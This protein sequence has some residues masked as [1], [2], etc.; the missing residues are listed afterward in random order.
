[1]TGIKLFDIRHDCRLAAGEYC[2]LVRE[3]D[4]EDPA[5]ATWAEELGG[6]TLIWVKGPNG[7][8][9]VCTNFSMYELLGLAA[10][11]AVFLVAAVSGVVT[12]YGRSQAGA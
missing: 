4:T 7:L 5:T 2:F 8:T 10:L 3:F 9:H 11:V 12:K 6:R 1:M